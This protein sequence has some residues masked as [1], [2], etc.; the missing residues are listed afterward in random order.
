[1]S[2]LLAYQILRE[3]GGTEIPSKPVHVKAISRYCKEHH[4]DVYRDRYIHTGLG[5]LRHWKYITFNYQDNTYTI[6][7]EYEEPNIHATPITKDDIIAE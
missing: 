7:E 4:P 1:M 3:L 2:K 5:R 6:I